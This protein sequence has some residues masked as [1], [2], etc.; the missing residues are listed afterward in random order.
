M[1]GCDVRGLMAELF[2]ETVRIWAARGAVLRPRTPAVR[3]TS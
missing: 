2:R 1:R 3:Q